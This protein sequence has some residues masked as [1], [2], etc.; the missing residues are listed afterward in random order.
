MLKEQ[1]Y[2][3]LKHCR[4]DYADIRFENSD[5]TS[6]S[7]RGKEQENASTSVKNSGII[8]ACIKG[9]WGYVTLD[10]LE[11]LPAKVAQA[12][13]CARLVSY[14]KSSIAD[15]Q[16]SVDD[17]PAAMKD[18][19][20]MHSITEKI[21][22]I[23]GYND[24]VLAAAPRIESSTVRY[25]DRFRT[26]HFASTRGACFM[27]ERP[28]IGLL[29]S[30]YA[31]KGDIVQRAFKSLGSPDDYGIVLGKEREAEW[32]ANMADQLLDAPKCPGGRTTVILDPAFTGLF[33]HE[34]FGHLSEADFLFENPQVR[35][36]MQIGRKIGPDFLNIVDDGALPG[37]MGSHHVD[38]E[39]TPTRRNMLV[40][41]GNIT[42]HLHSLETAAIMGEEPTGNARAISG[43]KPAIVRMTNT[44]IE[45]GTHTREELFADVDDGIYAC[46]GLGGQTMMEMFTFTASYGYKIRNGK[47]AELLRDVMVT[48]NVF[49]TLQSIDAI[50]SDFQISDNSG[51]CGKSGQSPLP[52][53]DGGPHIRIRNAVVAGN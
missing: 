34:A 42:G 1:L 48:G 53:S 45:P 16:V 37:H 8:R 10:S 46:E 49:D 26:V 3:A 24:I 43:T 14:G 50:S 51:G 44:F 33:T 22:A 5:T 35:E 25:T 28:F 29:I 19:F 13:Q 17:Y 30:A 32:A 7:F 47:R 38:D 12:C 27:E 11:D 41:N 6:F 39:G 20:R 52:V 36:L 31:R 9:G 21:K 4:A 18:D 23:S 15:G 2:D 40:T